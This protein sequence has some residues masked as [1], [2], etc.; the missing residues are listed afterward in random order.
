MNSFDS[1]K[2]FCTDESLKMQITDSICENLTDS[3]LESYPTFCNRPNDVFGEEAKR[4]L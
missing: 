2:Y 1:E 3:D 4:W